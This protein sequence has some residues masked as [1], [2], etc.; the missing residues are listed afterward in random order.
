MNKHTMALAISLKLRSNWEKKS[1]CILMTTPKMFR[2]LI[3]LYR[4]HI[5]M[6]IAQYV[7]FC[8]IERR[9]FKKI[10]DSNTNMLTY[11]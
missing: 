8:T 4:Y 6:C 11:K 2:H 7:L 9:F 1:P 10:F 5:W 3:F